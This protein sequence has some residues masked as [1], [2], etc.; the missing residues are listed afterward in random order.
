[1]GFHSLGLRVIDLSERRLKLHVV[2]AATYNLCYASMLMHLAVIEP[3]IWPLHACI[4]AQ[5]LCWVG[6]FV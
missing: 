1:M 3:P 2:S 5:L 4:R 6:A